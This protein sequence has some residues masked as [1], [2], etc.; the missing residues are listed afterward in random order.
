[1]ERITH[2]AHTL[3]L[4]L[5][6]WPLTSAEESQR[7]GILLEAHPEHVKRA[8]WTA[9]AVLRAAAAIPD[10]FLDDRNQDAVRGARRMV[11]ARFIR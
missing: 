2:N 8:I 1:M 3:S 9:E 5:F 6:G 10:R 7:E 4:N 11:D